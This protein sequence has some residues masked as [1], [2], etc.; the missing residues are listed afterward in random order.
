[1]PTF[2][3]TTVAPNVVLWLD[4]SDASTLISAATGT[5]GGDV[6]DGGTVGTWLD[7]SGQGNHFSQT[8]SGLRPVYESTGTATG[9]PCIKFYDVNTTTNG[10]GPYLVERVTNKLI[11]LMPGSYTM[12]MG[13]D[14]KSATTGAGGWVYHAFIG[15]NGLGGGR[16]FHARVST[17]WNRH[18]GDATSAPVL[19]TGMHMMGYS[20]SNTTESQFSEQIYL[21]SATPALTRTEY[22]P[23]GVFTENQPT[24]ASY[25]GNQIAYTQSS[26]NSDIYYVYIWAGTLSNA[27]IS[28]AITGINAQLGTSVSATL[29]TLT[30]PTGLVAANVTTS[31]QRITTLPATGGT[32][33]IPGIKVFRSTTLGTAAAI[34]VLGNLIYSGNAYYYDD[35]GLTS[36]TNYY[37][38]TEVTQGSAILSPVLTTIT[39]GTVAIKIVVLGDSMS[40]EYVSNV[41]VA[42]WVEIY[43]STLYPA[44]NVTCY[45]HATPGKK[46]RDFSRLTHSGATNGSGEI[47]AITATMVSQGVQF[48]SLM[49][50]TNDW[51]AGRIEGTP[52][53][54]YSK[55]RYLLDVA[56][57]C[58]CLN[59]AGIIVYV[60]E[61]CWRNTAGAEDATTGVLGWNSALDA[62]LG[63]TTTGMIRRGTRAT[64]AATL[65]QT[66]LFSDGL[67]FKGEPARS[68]LSLS[69]ATA[70]GQSIYNGVWFRQGRT[71]GQRWKR[72]Y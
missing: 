31:A 24:T 13:C 17:K 57:I 6:V 19:N 45:S 26:A 23:P 18:P 69:M 39:R 49:V 30:A 56:D 16:F 62:A 15:N 66:S 20:G 53:T 67:H 5:T 58:A 48:C 43:L 71:R 11:N 54:N 42:K 28:A 14:L 65:N 29:G 1:M 41:S 46:A 59:A 61:M 2:D 55:A 72:G 8:T 12:L 47:T 50:G 63:F 32:A 60:H 64:F 68:T 36:Q 9:T 27:Q 70:M 22:V 40:T 4:A 44:L 37:Y 25:I 38:V 35:S 51:N 10:T 34:A 52:Y 33:G 21:D 3:P 7:K